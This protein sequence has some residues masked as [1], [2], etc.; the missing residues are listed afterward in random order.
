MEIKVRLNN[1]IIKRKRQVKVET[2]IK[3]SSPKCNINSNN[4][5]FKISKYLD[6]LKISNS[7]IKNKATKIKE[8]IKV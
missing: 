1:I 4:N 2:R 8:I 7:T 6:Q 5:I 3:L